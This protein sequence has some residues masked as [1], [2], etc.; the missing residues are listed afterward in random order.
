MDSYQV[1]ERKTALIF[2][3]AVFII[4]LVTGLMLDGSYGGGDGIRH[5][6]VSKWSWQHPDLFLY[7]WGKPFFTLLTSPFSQFG[8][9]G[10]KLFNV[11]SGTL[12]CFLA[13]LI[14]GK[15]SYKSPSWIIVFSAFSPIY[16]MCI[17]SGLTEPL[18]ALILT[19]CIYLFINSQYLTATI[20]LSFLPFVRSEGNMMLPL[21]A[22]I[23]LLRGQWKYLPLLAFGTVAYSIVGYF[24]Y[25]DIFWIITKNPYTGSNYDIYGQGELLHFVKAYDLILGLPL[26]ILF[27]IGLALGAVYFFSNFKSAFRQKNLILEEFVLV[28]GAFIV[29]FVAHT[30]FWWKGLYGSL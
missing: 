30:I 14:A 23:L 25:K 24:H 5:F 22:M 6:L 20:L 9:E 15:L 13:Y 18:F 17:N 12:T 16:I 26:T 21:F 8:L 1:H 3:I 2:L 11:I 19:L 29:Y 10:I 27:C 28:Y 7:H 4:Y